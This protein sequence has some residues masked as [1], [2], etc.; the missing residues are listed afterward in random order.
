[1]KFLFIFLI[2][3]LCMITSCDFNGNG[4]TPPLAHI[5]AEKQNLGNIEYSYCYDLFNDSE[6]LIVF[7]HGAF[8]G[9]ESWTKPSLLLESQ[10]F[11]R[12]RSR[13]AKE[14]RVITISLGSSW[15]LTKG[16][17]KKIPF[18]TIDDFMKVLSHLENK[19]FKP[20]RRF[21]IGISMGGAN[22]LQLWLHRPKDFDRVVVVNALQTFCYAYDFINP[23]CRIGSADLG[24]AL[25]LFMV[26]ANYTSKSHYDLNDLEKAGG[27]LVSVQ[28][29]PLQIHIAEGDEFMFNRGGE[30]IYN[31]IKNKAPVELVKNLLDHKDMNVAKIVEFLQK[32]AEQAKPSLMSRI[33]GWFK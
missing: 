15:L 27:N 25:S 22:A 17:N 33:M 31:N 3:T 7:M 23:L 24:V 18:S 16:P 5:C 21:L 28:H 10:K 26:R 6:N 19:H 14:P 30:A 32:P 1:M 20:K 11:L 29:P 4:N 9:E 8:A 2:L 12:V 13:L